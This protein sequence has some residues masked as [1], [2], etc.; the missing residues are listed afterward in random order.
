MP[1]KS[2]CSKEVRSSNIKELVNS[3]RSLS[4]AIA[5]AISFARKQGCKIKPKKKK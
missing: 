4:Q 2:G 1:L 3:S 5:I